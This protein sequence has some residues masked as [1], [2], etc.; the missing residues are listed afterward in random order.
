MAGGKALS[1]F[2][3]LCFRARNQFPNSGHRQL[4]SATQYAPPTTSGLERIASVAQSSI[5]S[6]VSIAMRFRRCSS[7]ATR[8]QSSWRGPFQVRQNSFGQRHLLMWPAPIVSRALTELL[9]LGRLI[10]CCE[11]LIFGP[12]AQHLFSGTVLLFQRSIIITN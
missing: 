2:S 3:A 4:N 7:P 9:L 1:A 10:T 11:V 6:A 12:A 5:I 8:A